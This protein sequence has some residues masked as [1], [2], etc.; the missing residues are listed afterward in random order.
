MQ[1][2]LLL[3][4]VSGLALG[5]TQPPTQWVPEASSW[6][7]KRPERKDDHLHSSRE[8]AASCGDPV[9][10][11]VT[12]CQRTRS[13]SDFHKIRYR[14]ELKFRENPVRKS[15]ASLNTAAVLTISEVYNDRFG[16]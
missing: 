2:I 4:K 12:R 16:F 15:N 11:S 3:S 10:T 9:N 7:T 1:Q 8:Q 6:A 5:G 14:C 13:F